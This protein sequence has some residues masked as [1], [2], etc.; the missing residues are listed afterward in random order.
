MEHAITI[1]IP[2]PAAKVFTGAQIIMIGPF[3]SNFQV[4]FQSDRLGEIYQI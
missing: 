3:L 1:L 2:E 4:K